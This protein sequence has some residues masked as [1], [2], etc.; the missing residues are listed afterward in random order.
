M[1]FLIHGSMQQ[2]TQLFDQQWL[3]SG[4]KD[5]HLVLHKDLNRFPFLGSEEQAKQFLALWQSSP[6][7][8]FYCQGDLF[9]GNLYQLLEKDGFLLQKEGEN[10]H[11]QS[12]FERRVSL[13]FAYVNEQNEPCALQFFY[14]KDEPGQ[15]LVAFSKNAHLAPQ[16]RTVSLLASFDLN[17]YIKVAGGQDTV[18]VSEVD[19]LANSLHEGLGSAFV[20]ELFTRAFQP[21][22]SIINSDIKR[23]RQLM[24]YFHLGDE[25]G[26]LSSPLALTALNLPQL[27]AVN[28]ALDLITD[29]NLKLSAPMLYECLAVPD[30]VRKEIEALVLTGDELVNRCLLMSTLSFYEAGIL[31]ANRTFLQDQVLRKT[32]EQGYLWHEE[33]LSLVPFLIKKRYKADLFQL[34]LSN[35]AYYRAVSA[36]VRLGLSQDIPSYFTDPDKLK[37]LD[38]INRIADA[39]TRDLCYTLW[40]K[41]QLTFNT[42]Q[43]IINAAQRYP[44]MASTLLALD[45]EGVVSFQD[46]I[47]LAL[48][49]D[50]HLK[51]SFF[52]HFSLYFRPNESI[53]EKMDEAIKHF[54]HYF[55]LDESALEKLNTV[56]LVRLNN[57]CTVLKN[58]GYTDPN[59]YALVVKNNAPGAL[60]RLFLPQLSTVVDEN[61]QRILIELLYVGIDKGIVSQGKMAQEIEDPVL[62]KKAVSL[63]ERFICVKQMQRLNFKNDLITL[64]AEPD[65][66]GAAK[67]RH[68]ILNVEAQCKKIDERLQGSQQDRAKLIAWQSMEIDYKKRLYDLAYKAIL[69]PGSEFK[70]ELEQIQNKVL[71][72]IDPELKSMVHRTL[73]IIANIIISILTIGI[74]NRIK[75]NATGNPWFFTQTASGEDLRAVDDDFCKTIGPKAP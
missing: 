39:N 10:T 68:I 40:V 62:Q 35:E 32:L 9:G 61:Q 22:T 20:K 59:A 1:A 8:Q 69:Y 57:A 43:E 18:V 2:L 7:K 46:L 12:Y 50:E 38:Y 53:L 73:I 56:E 74:A 75:N 41:G 51:K 65:H 27:F 63:H 30:G 5:N 45:K 11:P 54:G 36:L 25:A 16:D 60:F 24:R 23:I 19:F 14:R 15:W 44:L 21:G 55:R 47:D 42:Y 17:S 37:E 48:N 28:R 64:V 31:D 49:P 71:K 72:E 58:T 52:Y 66:E 29:Y 3:A 4:H 13:S 26:L 6:N 34:V 67:L 70:A 33:Q